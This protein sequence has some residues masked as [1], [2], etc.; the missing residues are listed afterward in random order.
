MDEWAWQTRSRPTDRQRGP[1]AA[2]V[3]SHV[4]SITDTL[5]LHIHTRQA[6]RNTPRQKLNQP[7]VETAA[8]ARTR[9][10]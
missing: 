8:K 9:L 1:R 3:T 4:N 2:I 10:N 6:L 7:D 5:T